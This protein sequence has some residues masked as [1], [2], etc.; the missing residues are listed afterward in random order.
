MAAKDPVILGECVI[1]ADLS[2]PMMANDHERIYKENFTVKDKFLWHVIYL[3]SS[4]LLCLDAFHD[5]DSFNHKLHSWRGALK[6]S[7]L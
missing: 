7:N 3:L 1:A 6:G 2:S 4:H 5:T